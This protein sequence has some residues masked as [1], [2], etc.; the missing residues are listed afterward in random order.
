MDQNKSPLFFFHRVKPGPRVQKWRG[1]E[2][3]NWSNGELE[4]WRDGEMAE[5]IKKTPA[6]D[7][8]FSIPPVLHPSS[9]PVL[10]LVLVLGWAVH[11][12]PGCGSMGLL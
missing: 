3:R 1:G 2:L 9:P 10:V 4:D 7:G 6:A 11:P 12:I 8:Y 5:P